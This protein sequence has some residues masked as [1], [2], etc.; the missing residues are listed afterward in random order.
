MRNDLFQTATELEQ[1][2]EIAHASMIYEALSSTDARAA[3]NLGTI[4]YKRGKFERAEELYRR[5]TTVAPDY[6]LGFYN[7]GNALDELKYTVEATEAYETAI[8]LD[9]RCL[10]AH[11]NLALSLDATGERRRAVKHW[12]A[13]VRLDSTGPH[14]DHAR[15][16]IRR[17]I[18]VDSLMIVWRGA[19]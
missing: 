17:T 15:I 13:Y 6:A 2:G 10:D 19:A 14:A 4:H 9:P 1:N 18:A 5:A 7:L 16:S 11:Y 8:R 3:L 12:R